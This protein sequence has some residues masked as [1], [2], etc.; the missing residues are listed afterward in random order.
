MSA[1]PSI[2]LSL[3]QSSILLRRS[4][5]KTLVQQMP[6]SCTSHKTI[7]LDCSLAVCIARAEEGFAPARRFWGASSFYG[8][9]DTRH[10]FSWYILR[11]ETGPLTTT[12]LAKTVALQITEAQAYYHPSCILRLL[13]LSSTQHRCQTCFRLSRLGSPASEKQP[14]DYSNCTQP[15]QSAM[16]IHSMGMRLLL[17]GLL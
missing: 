9:L 8:I 16:F 17:I 5:C 14:I 1:I 3:I 11:C 15:F 4:P 2:S 6:I 10:E 7:A 12:F 13:S